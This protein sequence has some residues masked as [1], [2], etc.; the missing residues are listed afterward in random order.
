MRRRR[1][2]RSPAP[3]A[4]TWAP[5]NGPTAVDDPHDTSYVQATIR[6]EGETLGSGRRVWLRDVKNVIEEAIGRER[7]SSTLAISRKKAL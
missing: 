6:I 4:P 2:L 7:I 5:W 3:L 1:G